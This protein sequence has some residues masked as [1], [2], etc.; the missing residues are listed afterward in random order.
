MDLPPL[1]QLVESAQYLITQIEKHPDYQK[2]DYQPDLTIGD[3][4]SALLYL[5]CE[6]EDN[7]QLSVVFE[8]AD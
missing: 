6:L 2:L 4:Q 7:Q 3:A 8:S 1:L 5:K